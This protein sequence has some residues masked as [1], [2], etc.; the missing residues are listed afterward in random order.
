MGSLDQVWRRE[1]RERR[2]GQWLGLGQGA[3]WDAWSGDLEM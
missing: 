3:L 1:R 2:P